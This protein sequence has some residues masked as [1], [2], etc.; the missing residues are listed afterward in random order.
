MKVLKYKYLMILVLI[1]AAAAAYF[2]FNKKPAADYVTAAI[3]RGSLIQTVSQTGTVK[4]IAE[5]DLNFPVAG[6][7]SKIYASVGDKI[8]KDQTLAELDSSDLAL[9]KREAE[10]NLRVAQANLAKLLAGTAASEL[11]VGQANADQAKNAYTA[12]VNEAEKIKNV[13]SLNVAQ[14]QKNLDNLYLTSGDIIS[15]EQQA[16]KNYQT[17]A[18]N[19]IGFKITVAANALDNINTILTDSDA[20][21][22][23][24]ASDNSL[25]AAVKDNYSEANAALA[26]AKADL[27]PAKLSRS[28]SDINSA[29]NSAIFSLSQTFSALKHAYSLLEATIAGGNFTQ[30]NLNTYKTNISAQQTNVT[31]GISALQTAQSNLNDALNDLNNEISSAKDDLATAQA[32]SSE[33]IAAANAKVDNSYRLYQVALAQLSQL[34]AGARVQDINLNQAQISQAQAALDLVKNQIANNIIKAPADGVITKKNY[35]AGEQSSPAKPVFSLLS[36]NN[37][38]IE[39]DVSEADITKVVLNNPVEITL[40]AFGPDIKFSGRVNFI[41][42]AETIIQDV[43]YYKVKINFDGNNLAV[44]SGMTANAN[45]NTAKK[46]DVITMPSRAMIEKDGGKYARQLLNGQIRETPITIGLRGDNGLVEVLSGLS[47]G[48]M[49]VTFIQQNQ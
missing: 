30:T 35:E 24:G 1:G 12:A 25:I 37:F 13:H 27:P 10:A 48:D 45:I 46:D 47:Q 16:I 6:K 26:V 39:V 5:I 42:P 20:K 40:D 7:I 8:K 28:N 11:A 44:K 34:K 41:E 9:K 19:A 23:L 38:E 3:T 21:N 36:S 18:L 33:K 22:F 15:S 43:V 17:E 14:A 49:V 32:N 4:A 31:S 29:L 2:I